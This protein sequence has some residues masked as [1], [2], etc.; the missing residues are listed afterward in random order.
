MG[1]LIIFNYKQIILWWQYVTVAMIRYVWYDKSVDTWQI[2]FQESSKSLVYLL[3][4]SEECT[5]PLFFTVSVKYISM[6]HFMSLVLSAFS[7]PMLLFVESHTQCKCT[8]GSFH[9]NV[10][11]DKLFFFFM[12]IWPFFMCITIDPSPLGYTMVYKM[13]IVLH[14][15]QTKWHIYC[16]TV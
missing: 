15:W 11:Y 8:F 9:E 6:F 4:N 3:F 14:N 5:V 7:L 13:G 10:L 1:F 12:T 16:F 2:N